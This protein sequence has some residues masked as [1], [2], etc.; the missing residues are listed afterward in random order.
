MVYSLGN[1][2]SSLDKIERLVDGV[3]EVN[4][5]TTMLALNA[6][7]EA[8]RAGEAGKTFQVVAREVRDLATRVDSLASDIRTE[9][10]V[11]NGG[12]RSTH[13]MLVEFAGT[14]MSPT[15]MAE[16]RMQK[17]MMALVR[18]NEQLALHL[19]GSVKTAEQATEVSRLVTTFQFQ[20]RLTQS[21]QHISD[22]MLLF[23]RQIRGLS[24]NTRE[25]AYANS[26]DRL[27]VAEQLQKTL[28]G[29]PLDSLRRNNIGRLIND[30]KTSAWHDLVYGR[31]MAG[32]DGA[33]DDGDDIELF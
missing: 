4:R 2:V 1:V 18:Q 19:R 11:I 16:E 20:D 22:T 17:L 25:Q 9:M 28:R 8:E 7:I 33:R 3:G 21:L 12:I 31:S 29:L 30:Y 15:L 23:E 10:E 26:A 5:K 6:T 24:R 32:T 27:N 14:D 13:H